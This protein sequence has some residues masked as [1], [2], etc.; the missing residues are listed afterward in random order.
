MT[1]NVTIFYPM[2]A[3]GAWLKSTLA[4]TPLNNQKYVNFHGWST[5]NSHSNQQSWVNLKHT[6]EDI[7]GSDLIFSGSSY[8]NFFVNHIYKHYC[9]EKDIFNK[10]NYDYYWLTIVAASY[11]IC[12]YNKFIDVLYFNFDDLIRQPDIFY[13]KIVEL[14]T[15]SNKPVIDF[16]NFL[17]RQKKFIYTCVNI[18]GMIENFDNMYWVAFVLGQLMIYKI[19]PTFPIAKIDNQDRCKQFARDNYHNCKLNNFVNFDTTIFLPKFL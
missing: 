17:F 11:G 6:I 1:D 15:N 8:F 18:N 13:K 19:H 10:N 9:Y 3:G 12:K 5:N 14:Q 16:D 4:L 2:G 7:G